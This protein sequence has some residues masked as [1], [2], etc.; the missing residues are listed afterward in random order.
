[1]DLRRP[2]CRNDLVPRV[3][4]RE[5]R[6]LRG[7]PISSLAVS[8]GVHV[9]SARGPGTSESRSVGKHRQGS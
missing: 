2:L 3:Y 6:G 4:R 5:V 7:V 1:M 9:T 8:A